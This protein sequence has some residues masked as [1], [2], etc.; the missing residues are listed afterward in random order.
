MV[1]LE[2][3]FQKQPQDRAKITRLRLNL[4]ASERAKNNYE[5][6]LCALEKNARDIKNDMKG[7]L[8][9]I[10]S[11][12]VDHSENIQAAQQMKANYIRG[13]GQEKMVHQ[14]LRLDTLDQGASD[15]ELR[16]RI[17]QTLRNKYPPSDMLK[18]Y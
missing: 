12:R 1:K 9:F 5:T 2:N 6:E 4:E 17:Q 13:I 7:T 15:Q 10:E 16:E 8:E 18:V 14:E 11:T 3:E